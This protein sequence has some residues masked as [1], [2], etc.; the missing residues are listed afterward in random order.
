M[1]VSRVPEA[2]CAC[3]SS[4][5]ERIDPPP[6]PFPPPRSRRYYAYILRAAK[7][8]SNGTRET[9]V[10]MVNPKGIIPAA[11]VNTALLG[12]LTTVK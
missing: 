2:T 6:P 12:Y 5:H 10:C 4:K 9:L 3:T 7:D 8:G 11:L 1:I